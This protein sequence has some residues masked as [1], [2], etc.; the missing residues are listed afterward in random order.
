MDL[1]LA[2]ILT[3]TG[4]AAAA[5]LITGT[6][7]VLK[8]SLPIIGK[9]GWEQSLALLFSLILVLLAALDANV[10]TLPAAFT[11]FVAWLSIAKLATGI[12]DEVTGAPGSIR[13]ATA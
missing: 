1:T 2:S 6:I 9:R 3:V 8:S 11:V 4:A 5:A 10:R 12:H 13:E 7:E